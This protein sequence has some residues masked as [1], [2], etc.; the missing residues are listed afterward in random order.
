MKK[1]V[2]G[3][4]CG[5]DGTN[6]LCMVLKNIFL[7]NGE[8]GGVIHQ[9]HHQEIYNLF[10]GCGGDYAEF[11]ESLQRLLNDFRP[12]TGI[13]GNGYALL[14]NHIDP[15]QRSRVRVVHLFRDKEDWMG[16]YMKNIHTYPDSH[17]NYSEAVQPKIYRMA[18]WH[19]GECT[20]AKWEERSVEARLSW[21]YDKS[22][23]MIADA[24]TLGYPYLRI[25]TEDLSDVSTVAAITKFVDSAWISPDETCRANVSTIDYAALS[26]DDQK[27][28]G[29]VY[30][31]FDYVQAAHDPIYGV[32][33]FEQQVE[34]GFLH[35]NSYEHSTV[36][37]QELMRHFSAVQEHMKTLKKMLNDQEGSES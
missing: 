16:S 24:E 25:R 11:K 7:K 6:S 36:S 19:F 29:R 1:M 9:L 32:R 13:V 8:E 22:H 12:G 17:G 35:R 10:H 34:N 27:V 23:E 18:A 30:S 20:Q 2:L 15:Q 5:R 3:V 33:F 21:Y 37:R 26:D 28:L 31:Q 4:G 14:L